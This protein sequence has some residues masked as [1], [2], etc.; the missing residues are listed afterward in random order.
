MKHDD[1]PK[2]SVEEKDDDQHQTSNEKGIITISLMTK[3]LLLHL[4]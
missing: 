1:S 4:F 2:T 3:S